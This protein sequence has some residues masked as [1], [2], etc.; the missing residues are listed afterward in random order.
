M[1]KQKELK[2][3]TYYKQKGGNMNTKTLTPFEATE[4]D[5]ARINSY[6]RRKLNTEEIYTFSMILCANDVDRDC[7]A[8]TKEA[9]DKMSKLFE[10]TTG[11]QDHKAYS[12]N[13]IAR[14]FKT[15]VIKTNEK[16]MYGEDKY[17]LKAWAYMV[18]SE[19]NKDLILKIDAGIV[20]E[21]SVCCNIKKKICSI[22]GEKYDGGCGHVLG[23]KYGDSL[24]YVKLKEPCDAYEWSFVAVPA[25]PEAGVVKHFSTQTHKDNEFYSKA[26]IGE[27][28]ENKLKTQVVALSHLNNFMKENPS[29]CEKILNKLSIKE[30]E[31]LKEEFSKNLNKSTIF[32]N[33][34][35]AEKFRK[36]RKF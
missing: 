10:G 25:Q 32:S 5:M 1:H 9:L 22:C 21:V 12:K 7:E 29:C 36:R 16:T 3:K 17:L 27:Y 33:F 18:K 30:L 19:N 8:F 15:S 2:L 23:K 28:F 11:I 35:F 34:S 26:S 31:A 6:S 4:K 20:K 24:C 14:I 13:Q